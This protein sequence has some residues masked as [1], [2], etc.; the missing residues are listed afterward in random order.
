MYQFLQKIFSKLSAKFKM[1]IPLNKLPCY[2]C[3]VFKIRII[4]HLVLEHIIY[5]Q[6]EIPWIWA[7]PLKLVI[8]SFVEA[9]GQSIS[10]CLFY[11]FNSP[12]KCTKKS[13]LL[14]LYLRSNCFRLFFGRIGDPKKT[15]K[16]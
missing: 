5:S 6:T 16:N 3:I 9:K 15:F 14:P 7:F 1:S 8:K 11:I 4:I 12:K 13:T 2:W 10:K